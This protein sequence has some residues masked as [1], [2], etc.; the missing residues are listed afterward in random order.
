MYEEINV[1]K[2]RKKELLALGYFAP[3]KP[4]VSIVIVPTGKKHDSGW[5]CMK[6]ILLD[7]SNK[8]CG[9]VGGGSDVIHLTERF[10][11]TIKVYPWKVDCLPVSG[12]VSFWCGGHKLETQPFAASDFTVYV[13]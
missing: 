2:A 10:D 12:C 8:I 3:T 4:V 5:G 9:V 6:F 11:K 1:M 7:D 13:K